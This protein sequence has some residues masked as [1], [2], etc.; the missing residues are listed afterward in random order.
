MGQRFKSHGYHDRYAGQLLEISCQGPS[1]SNQLRPVIEINIQQIVVRAMDAENFSIA[2]Q[3][4]YQGSASF[5]HV[6]WRS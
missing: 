2:R 4:A 6:L 5:L 1:S 3:L